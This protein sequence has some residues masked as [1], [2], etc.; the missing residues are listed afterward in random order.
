MA[1]VLIIPDVHGRPFWK[2][3]VQRYPD[4]DTIFLGDYHDPYP[5]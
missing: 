4:T 5:E 2:D 1:E 3:A